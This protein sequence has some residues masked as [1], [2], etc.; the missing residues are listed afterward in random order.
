MLAYPPTETQP[1]QAPPPTLSPEIEEQAAN[2]MYHMMFGDGTP[3][4]AGEQLWAAWTIEDL[5]ASALRGESDAINVLEKMKLDPESHPVLG[6]A[7]E[8]ADLKEVDVLDA[9]LR[10]AGMSWDIATVDEVAVAW[11]DVFAA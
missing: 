3:D 8:A 4:P 5:I 7:A 6:I 9:I 2:A 1:I 10:R 11:T